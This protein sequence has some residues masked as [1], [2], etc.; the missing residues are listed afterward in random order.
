MLNRIEHKL[1]ISRR[2]LTEALEILKRCASFLPP[3]CQRLDALVLQKLDRGERVNMMPLTW[4]AGLHGH[5]PL[6]QYF[7]TAQT[8]VPDSGSDVEE[9]GDIGARKRKFVAFKRS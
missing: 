2:E 6:L 1:D 5:L 9:V 3:V 4:K 7:D 8:T